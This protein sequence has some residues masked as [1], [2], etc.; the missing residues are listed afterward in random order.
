MKRHKRRVLRVTVSPLNSK[1][2]M[3]DLECGH[4]VW[5][6]RKPPVGSMFPCRQCEEFLRTN[7]QPEASNE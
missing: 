5:V 4:E 6:S 3:A 2:K 1:R 7:P